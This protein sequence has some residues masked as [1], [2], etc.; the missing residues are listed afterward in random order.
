[1]PITRPTTTIRARKSSKKPPV[2]P[3]TPAQLSRV[4]SVI[5][6]PSGTA[7]FGAGKALIVTAEKFPERV[8]P[9][10]DAIAPLLRSESKIMRWTGM[11]ALAPLAEVDADR[12]I[13]TVLD[14][15]V[16]FI[17]GGNLISAANAVKCL[18]RIARYRPDLLERVLAVIL[19]VEN[20]TYETPECRRVAI[21]Q[22]LKVLEEMGEEVLRRPDVSAFVHRQRDCPRAAVAKLANQLLRRL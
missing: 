4:V 6:E 1:M 7:R 18:A 12:K 13:D 8:Y 16:S 3:L 2:R 15:Y 19:E 11:L 5:G 20:A 14:T 21:G 9:H 22:T 17:H 10:F